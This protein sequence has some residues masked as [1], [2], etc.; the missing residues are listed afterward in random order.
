MPRN[1]CPGAG[2]EVPAGRSVP[3]SSGAVG[4]TTLVETAAASVTLVERGTVRSLGVTGPL[5]AALDERQ[6]ETGFGRR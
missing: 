3:P 4:R 6:Y 1:G 5:A 2:A